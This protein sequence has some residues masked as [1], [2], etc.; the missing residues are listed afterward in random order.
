[1]PPR[2]TARSWSCR[3]PTARC[4]RP[5]STSCSPVRLAFRRS[6]C[7]LN[8]VDQVDDAELLELV[9]L[10]VRELLSMYEY[11]GDDNS[12]RGRLGAGG[13]G[14]IPTRKIGEDAVRKLMAE[15]DAYI[16][17]PERPIDMP[18]L[19]PIGTCSRISGRANGGDLSPRARLVKVERGS[20]DRR[21]TAR[22]VETTVTRVRCYRK[23]ARPGPGWRQHPRLLRGVTRGA[24][25]VACMFGNGFGEAHTKF[26]A[27]A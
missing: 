14:R 2:W 10:E 18:F 27:E 16:P 22:P 1:M 12:D 4:R 6:W 19:M 8:K 13:S 25:S 5:A 11:P 21:P 3:L 20:R 17:T 26:K 24:W 7:F 23:P 15:V 9:E